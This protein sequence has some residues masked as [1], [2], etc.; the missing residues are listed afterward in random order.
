M[1]SSLSCALIA[2]SFASMLAAPAYARKQTFVAAYGADVGA[3]SYT[4][5][6]RTLT[7]A[8][9]Q[10]DSEG[11]VTI[12]DS[13]GYD[14]IIIT[15]PVTVMAAPGAL[16]SLSVPPTQTNGDVITVSFVSGAVTLIGLTLDGGT[17]NAETGIAFLFGPRL[18]IKNSIVKNFSA[19]GIGLTPNMASTMEISDTLVANNGGHGVFLQ[20]PSSV[21]RV[22]AVFNR[23][24]AYGNALAGIGVFGNYNSGNG[25]DLTEATA[26]NC[27]AAHNNTGYQAYGPG[28]SSGNT[29]FHIT[30]STASSNATGIGADANA[31]A[32][33]SQSDL[34]SNYQSAWSTGNTGSIE[35]YND[36][37]TGEFTL[38]SGYT[39]LFTN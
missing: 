2:A 28:T 10:V 17:Q 11:V 18:I 29:N 36:N 24:E 22:S 37:H 38:T 14:S 34:V 21:G 1:R 3:C 25:N 7:Y 23:V 4:A 31:V 8:L 16:P 30:K 6:C 19:S 27:V 5:P 20:P 13:A 32:I 33:V 39:K 26:I 9:A 15:K 35:S 12:L